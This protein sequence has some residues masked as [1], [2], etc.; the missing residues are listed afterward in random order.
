MAVKKGECGDVGSAWHNDFLATSDYKKIPNTISPRCQ[1]LIGGR[2]A[3]AAAPGASSQA[4]GSGRRFGPPVE[5]GWRLIR[6]AG[7]LAPEALRLGPVCDRAS[8]G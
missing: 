8:L 7:C 2:G 5:N 6:R 4:K 1:I 3:G